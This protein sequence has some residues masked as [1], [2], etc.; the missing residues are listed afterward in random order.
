LDDKKSDGG[1]IWR[2]IR[3]FKRRE[4]FGTNEK[5]LELKKIRAE[6]D[7]GKR[8][9]NVGEEMMVREKMK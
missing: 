1:D 5:D 4:D 6:R 7:F 3:V 9:K 2:E 8:N